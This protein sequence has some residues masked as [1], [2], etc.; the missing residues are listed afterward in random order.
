VIGILDYG[1]GNLF[2]ISNALKK[3]NLDQ[4]YIQNLDDFNT[5]N[6]VIL[7]GVGSFKECIEKLKRKNFYNYLK[8]YSNS[9]KKL[10]GICIG[11]QMLF[12]N[13]EED[14]F[15][16]GLSLIKGNVKYLKNQV[17]ND[18]YRLSIPNMGWS[19]VY[20]RRNKKTDYF[21]NLKN[22]D[23]YFAHSL[24]CMLEEKECE[25]AFSKFGNLEFCSM[26]KKNQIYGIQFHP[27]KSGENGLKLL[28]S[29]LLYD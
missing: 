8:E 16:E 10:V 14:G 25:L 26:I 21:E 24:T 29:I 12:E 20:I 7:P 17:S 6:T 4:K 19:K 22:N 11:M 28:K 13:S 5:V 23:F 27:E 9:G 3:I 15:S 1:S 18:N 2:S